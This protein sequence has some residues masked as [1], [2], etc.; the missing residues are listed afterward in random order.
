MDK[1]YPFETSARIEKNQRRDASPCAAGF[2][3]QR[4][5]PSRVHR[6]AFCSF[7]LRLFKDIIVFKE[8][9]QIVISE[10]ALCK[11]HALI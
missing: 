9:Y 7:I 8:H 6:A 10:K 2:T 3:E 5:S 4:Y 1:K 11:D